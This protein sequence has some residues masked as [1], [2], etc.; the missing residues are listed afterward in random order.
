A[1]LNMKQ[2]MAKV[3]VGMEPTG[4]YWLN[5]A[6]FLK[7]QGIK[8]VVVNPMH[9]KKSKELDDNSPTKNDVKDARVIAQLVKDG[10]YAEPNIP[11]GVYAE[12]RVARKIRDFLSVDLQAVQGQIHNWLDRYFPEFTTVFKDWEGK[13]ALQLLQL[14]LLPGELVKLSDEEILVH[15]KKAVKR[16][17]GAGK[18]KEIKQAAALSIGI[19]EGAE[20]A[21]MEILTLLDKYHLIKQKFEELEAKIDTLLEQIPGVQQM[22]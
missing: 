15:L 17:V 16:A 8:F 21:K 19:R 6:H 7:E 12:L 18:V 10:R 9:V 2:G 14:G 1:Q 22:I 3:I 20:M 11:Q 5:L 13:A 4:H